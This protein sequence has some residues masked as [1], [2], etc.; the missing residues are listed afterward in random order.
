MDSKGY[1]NE[2]DLSSELDL[3]NFKKGVAFPFEKL[4]EIVY[5]DSKLAII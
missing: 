1:E 4:Q 3:D 2:S 5:N